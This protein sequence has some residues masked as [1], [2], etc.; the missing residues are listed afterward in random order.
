MAGQSVVLLQIFEIAILRGQDKQRFAKTC[1]K[2]PGQLA[3]E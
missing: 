3:A 1:E 2:V